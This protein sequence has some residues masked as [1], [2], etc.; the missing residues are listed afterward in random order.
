MR[1]SFLFLLLLGICVPA[2]ALAQSSTPAPTAQPGAIEF[3]NHDLATLLKAVKDAD[4]SPK[5]RIDVVGKAPSE[6]PDY[7]PIVHFAEGD[8]STAVATIWVMKA[9]PHTTTAANAFAAAMELACMSTGFAGPHLEND[10]RPGCRDGC[11]FARELA[12]PVQI[13]AGLNAKDSSDR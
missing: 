3:T 13:S 5:I 6:M 8:A 4:T 12:Q 2:A 1:I 10:L 9:A 7:D 11:G